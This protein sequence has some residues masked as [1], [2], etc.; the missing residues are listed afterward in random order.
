MR[1]DCQI[2]IHAPLAGC[3]KDKKQWTVA[4]WISIH[5]PLAGCDAT[6]DA[7]GNATVISIHAPLAGCD[8]IGAI[9]RQ[10][11]AAISIHAP[12]AGCDH[13]SQTGHGGICHFNPRTPCGVRH[14]V[15]MTVFKRWLISIHAPLAGCDIMR[16][17][18]M[19]GQ[20]IFQS[21]HPLRGA[22]FMA[23]RTAPQG[24]GISIHAPLAGCD[25]APWTYHNPTGYFNP[26][27]PCGVRR[28]R[29][30]GTS[31]SSIFQSTHP[32]RGA[33]H[34]LALKEGSIDFN[35]RTPCGVRLP[36]VL[37]LTF[38]FADFNP[39]TPCGVRLTRFS[40]RSS[41]DAISIHAPLAG[42]D[43]YCRGWNDAVKDFNPRTPCGVRLILG[44]VIVSK[45]EISIHAP[46]AG[47]DTWISAPRR[48]SCISI[49]APLAGCDSKNVQRKL[50]F[51]ELADK[52]SA[53]IAAKKP[54]A[55]ADRCA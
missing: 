33:T 48:G 49:H 13:A 23:Q 50:H 43:D 44:I 41:Q 28:G 47:C 52:L 46:L 29:E 42:C 14:R 36:A 6:V 7:C 35:P 32:L 5:A 38:Q 40:R 34:G 12:L 1:P 55:K 18:A 24:K 3:D 31:Y 4:Q 26:R 11:A 27:T 8:A 51:F 37:S 10:R 53:R 19:R 45:R 16:T 54:S 30:L 21:T 15:R 20:A 25:R 39:R 9:V 2:S 22:T 17:L